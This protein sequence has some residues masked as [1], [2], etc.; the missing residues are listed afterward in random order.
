LTDLSQ[1]LK[2]SEHRRFASQFFEIIQKHNQFVFGALLNHR[3][4]AG[5]LRDKQDK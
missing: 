1:E 4:S 3:N 5:A 2:M